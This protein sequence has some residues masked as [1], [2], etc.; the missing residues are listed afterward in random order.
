MMILLNIAMIL[1]QVKEIYV[2]SK[3]L[4]LSV[5]GLV[6]M[7]VGFGMGLLIWILE[8]LGLVDDKKRCLQKRKISIM[9]KMW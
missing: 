6:T 5:L 3:F 1:F 7:A 2:L 9:M 4:E 8:G